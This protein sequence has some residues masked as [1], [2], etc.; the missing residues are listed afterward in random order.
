[1]G[2]SKSR[3]K[4]IRHSRNPFL[5]ASVLDGLLAFVAVLERQLTALLCLDQADDNFL[6][7][8]FRAFIIAQRELYEFVGG[9]TSTKIFAELFW[10]IG[11]E[12]KG[13]TNEKW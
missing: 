10:R 8:R 6:Q 3:T 11:H 9:K 1:M 13:S 5:N 2:A 7:M 4:Q 12:L